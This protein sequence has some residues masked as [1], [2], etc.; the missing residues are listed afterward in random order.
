MRE[1]RGQ[2]AYDIAANHHLTSGSDFADLEWLSG[3]IAL[4]ELDDPQ[5]AIRHFQRFRAGVD[6]PISLG[7]SAY[8]EAQAYRALDRPDDAQVALEFAAEFQTGFYGQLAADE[9]DAPMVP[10]VYD[11]TPESIAGASFV[12][13]PRVLA[14]LMLARAGRK[15]EAT[16][17]FSEV[18]DRLNDEERRK[19]G[20]LTV[21]VDQPHIAVVLA[22][23]AAARGDVLARP[24]FPM[25]ELAD[26]DVPPELVLSIIRRESEFN[27][28]ATSGAGAQGLMQLMPPTAREVSGQLRERY[29]KKAL[30][31]DPDYNMR[32]G[33]E[34]LRQLRQEFGDNV[35][36]VA[37]AYNAGPGRTRSWIRKYGDP[38][39]RN[40]DVLDWIENI[41]F[42]ETRNY[43][44][45]V[46]ES[47]VVYRARIN[48][49]PQ[50][51]RLASE[52]VD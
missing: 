16:L 13:D 46:A 1:G 37:S 45:R 10:E 30:T 25:S 15:P 23:Q 43:V 44:M 18:F 41:P 32:L 20:D 26:S 22:K 5:L 33:T 14:G 51:I 50:D 38:R 29:S 9:I 36:L 19:L 48:G 3:Y 35:I 49:G 21:M 8:W 6:S 31:E 2:V 17:F 7:R 28:L 40:V 52:I 12:R 27:P 47:V 42:R 39:R 24:Y 34:Y 4:T 11:A